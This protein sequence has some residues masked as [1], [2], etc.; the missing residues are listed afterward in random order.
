MKSHEAEA[1][2][3]RGLVYEQQRALRVASR[4][5]EQICVNEKM[6]QEDLHRLRSQGCTKK[7]QQETEQKWQD[8]LKAECHKLRQ[9]LTARFEQEKAQ[10]KEQVAKEKEEQIDTLRTQFEGEKR[11]LLQQVSASSASFKSIDPTIG[12]VLG[13]GSAEGHGTEGSGIGAADGIG[14]DPLGS[15]AVRIETGTEQSVRR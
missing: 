15:T 13:D 5:I 14:Q 11:Q 2:Q 8:K 10:I 3:L 1:S 4:Q 12:R 7:Q 6:L 9:E